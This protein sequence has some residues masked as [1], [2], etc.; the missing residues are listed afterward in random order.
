MLFFSAIRRFRPEQSVAFGVGILLVASGLLHMVV[1]WADGGSLSGPISW[2]KP[3]LFGLSAGVTVMSLGWVSGKMRQRSG[4]LLLVTGFSLAMLAEVALITLQQWRGVASHFNRATPF[5]A[6]VLRWTE[7][8]IFFATIVIAELTRRSFRPLRASADMVLAIRSGMALLL[9][10][11]LL[12]FVLVGYGNHQISLGKAPEV[13]GSAGVMKFPHGV[14]M[15]AIQFLPM[16]V[17]LMKKVGVAARDRFRS[18]AYALSS[19]VAFTTFSLL[20][21]F[22]GRARFDLSLASTVVLVG[23]I[24]TICLSVYV[25]YSPSLLLLRRSFSSSAPVQERDGSRDL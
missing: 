4:D 20:Q 10:S 23:S 6:A 14:P 18:V 11:C 22:G 1:C 9:F 24:T 12:G 3:I 2:R 16:L 15:H 21:T 17:W 13:Y 25:A 5:D 8:L 19:L 7:V